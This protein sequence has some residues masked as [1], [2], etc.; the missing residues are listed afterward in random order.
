LENEGNLEVADGGQQVQANV[1]GA[2]ASSV[3]ASVSKY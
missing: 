2:L 3:I 1:E